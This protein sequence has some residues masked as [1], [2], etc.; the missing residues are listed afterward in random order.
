MAKALDIEVRKIIVDPVQVIENFEFVS[1]FSS[2]PMAFNNATMRFVA[3]EAQKDNVSALYD[4]DGADRLF[5]GM[6]R[7]LV[8][9]KALRFYKI[10]RRTGLLP[11]VKLALGIFPNEELKKLSIHFQNWENGIQPYT[12]RNLDGLLV[13]N[14]EYEKK[15]YESSVK[16]FRDNFNR[17]FGLDDFGLFLT[18]Q[19]SYMCPEMFFNGPAE[20]QMELGLFPVPGF[21][22]DDLVSIALSI[23]TYLKLKRGKTKYILRKAASLN[24]DESYWMLPKIGLQNA[25]TFA[26]QSPEGTEWYNEQLKEIEESTEFSN[27]KEIL[28]NGLVQGKRLVSFNTW[29]KTL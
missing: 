12:E 7:H 5:L 27:L 9:Q 18:Y 10:F 24:L 23:P 25:F 17:E 6:N 2:E 15:V 16:R 21:W 3:L 13:Y 20:I 29:K 11:L 1:S 19:A 22:D 4:G 26:T 8:F 14:K 28:P